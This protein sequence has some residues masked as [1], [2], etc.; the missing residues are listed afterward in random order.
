MKQF[1]DKTCAHCGAIY[2]PTG[3]NSVF[4][5]RKCKRKARW[6]AERRSRPVG[7]HGGNHGRPNWNAHLR[8]SGIALFQHKLR[9]EAKSRRFCER[10][11]TDLLEATSKEWCAHHRDHD[12]TNNVASNIEL[13]C[14]RCHQIEHRC[15]EAFAA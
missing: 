4:C 1:T 8:T 11:S 13:L 12:R 9:Q 5:A 3:P 10:C 15:W 14:K 6:L 7:S 2:T